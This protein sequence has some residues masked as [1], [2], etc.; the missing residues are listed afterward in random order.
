MCDLKD[1]FALKDLGDL[2][3]FLGIEEKKLND[4]LLLTQ[5]KYDIDLLTK[6]GMK[7]CTSF[8]R[9]CPLLKNCLPL[10]THLLVM[11]IVQSIEALRVLCNI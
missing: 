9:H 8:P 10:R 6:F 11:M 2:H 5:E 1:D 7:N 3:F 4:G